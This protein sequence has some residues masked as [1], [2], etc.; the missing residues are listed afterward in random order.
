MKRH[1]D[2][3]ADGMRTRRGKTRLTKGGDVHAI[4]SGP[5]VLGVKQVVA[6][7]K[8]KGRR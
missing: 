3:I 1:A 5:N 8:Q 4:M 2:L 6:N 7:G